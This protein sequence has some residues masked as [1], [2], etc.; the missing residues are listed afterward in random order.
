M[1]DPVITDNTEEHRYEARLDGKLAGYLVHD[2]V[3]DV[4]DLPHTL[5]LPEYEGRGIAGRLT[6]HAL[7]DI[8]SRGLTVTPTCP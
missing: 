2:R 6:R 7:D 3:G 5:V 1:N 8:A 4:V